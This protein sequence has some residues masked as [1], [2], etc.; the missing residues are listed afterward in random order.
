MNEVASAA[1]TILTVVAR[2][3]SPPCQRSRKAPLAR[4][5]PHQR[6]ALQAQRVDAV[7][8]DQARDALGR[9]DPPR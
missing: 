6:A 8:A 5:L 1:K 4:G 7:L 2:N 3:S 9:R